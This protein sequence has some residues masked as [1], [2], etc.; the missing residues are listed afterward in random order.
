VSEVDG[1]VLAVL[2]AR[3]GDARLIDNQLIHANHHHHH[4]GGVATPPEAP[5]TA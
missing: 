2:A 1:E 4:H 5:T 3:V